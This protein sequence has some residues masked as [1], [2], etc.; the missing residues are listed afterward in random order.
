[1][2]FNILQLR[3]DS[4]ATWAAVNPVL[5]SGEVG[6][7]LTAMKIKVGNGV[8]SWNSLPFIGAVTGSTEFTQST[9]AATWTIN[10]NLGYRPNV[11]ALS[12]GGVEML[13]EISHTSVNQT[14]IYFD[15][16]T[17]GS[18]IYS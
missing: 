15:T 7:D 2:S 17:A 12:V 13:V 9:P 11:R 18:A 6:A 8:L 4:A 16:P 3:R 14:L 10:H 5:A 1:M